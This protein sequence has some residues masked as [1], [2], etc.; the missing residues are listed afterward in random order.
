MHML[1]VCAERNAAVL[2]DN[3]EALREATRLAGPADLL[4]STFASN[5]DLYDVPLRCDSPLYRLG[6]SNR[7]G[8]RTVARSEWLMD[9]AFW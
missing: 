4:M 9:T 3:A 7:E 1:C 8:F 6:V 2:R 5:P